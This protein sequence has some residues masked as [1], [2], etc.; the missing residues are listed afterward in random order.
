LGTFPAKTGA[1][2]IK[3]MAVTAKQIFR[4]NFM[5]V[6]WSIRSAV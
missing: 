3:A 2:L 6:R 5:M 4:D 1:P